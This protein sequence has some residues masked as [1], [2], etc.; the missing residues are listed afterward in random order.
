MKGFLELLWRLLS[1]IPKV[2]SKR[3][4][5][6]MRVDFEFDSTRDHENP[7][8]SDELEEASEQLK[9]LTRDEVN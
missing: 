5:F 8:E 3:R 9:R 7:E 2:S 6:K 1:L 4:R